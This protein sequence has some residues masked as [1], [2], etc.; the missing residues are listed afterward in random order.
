MSFDLCYGLKIKLLLGFAFVTA[1]MEIAIVHNEQ[2]AAW[3]RTRPQA[4]PVSA[5]PFF[6]P[7]EM[8]CTASLNFHNQDNINSSEC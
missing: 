5:C 8:L 2:G 4:E 3:R 1:L 6:H 7:G